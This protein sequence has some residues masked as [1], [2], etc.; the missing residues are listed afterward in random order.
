MFSSRIAI[1]DPSCVPPPQRIVDGHAHPDLAA[2]TARI[3]E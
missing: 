1:H 3:A 2:A